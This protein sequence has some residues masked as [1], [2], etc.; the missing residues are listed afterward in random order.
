MRSE[1]LTTGEV[2]PLMMG[3]DFGLAIRSGQRDIDL[4]IEHYEH[5]DLA[6]T[7]SEQTGRL[8]VGF[9]GLRLSSLKFCQKKTIFE[10]LVS[11]LI[12]GSRLRCDSG[13]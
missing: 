6:L 2:K 4:P 3:Y 13:I 11:Q 7:L 10:L 12:D 8:P 9:E 5:I 1:D